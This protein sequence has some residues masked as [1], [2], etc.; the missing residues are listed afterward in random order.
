MYHGFEVTS[1]G[2]PNSGGLQT[3][4]SLKLAEAADVTKRGDYRGSAD[5]M[6]SLIQIAKLQALLANSPGKRLKAVFP[7]FDPAP[8]SR[9]SAASTKRLLT[10][11]Q[12]KNW[13]ADVLKKT[14]AP[15]ARIR[16]RLSTAFARS[17]STLPRS[18]ASH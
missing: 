8:E 15:R 2:L 10:I 4:G 11:L 17:T 6:Y 5:S 16:V 13:Y 1:L 14:H 12:N 7:G 18:S 3:L 9:L